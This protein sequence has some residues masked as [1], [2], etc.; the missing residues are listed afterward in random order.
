MRGQTTL[1]FAI[2][3]ALFLGVVL[4]VFTF[5]PGILDPFELGGEEEPALSDRIANSLSKGMLG[6]AEKPNVLDR[7]C[8]VEF[9][10]GTDPSECEFDG[11]TLTER[12]NLSGTQNVNVTLLGNVSGAGK[13][14]LCWNTTTSQLGE[15]DDASCDSDDISLEMGGEP[16]AQATTIT[17]RR[18]VTLYGE[19]VTMEV[20]VW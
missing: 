19:S 20:V 7:Y 15:T 4:F 11:R 2:G 12:F 10:N 8:T 6:S 5:V 18:V 1:D 13:H 9:F 3:I 17:A 16:P 14:L